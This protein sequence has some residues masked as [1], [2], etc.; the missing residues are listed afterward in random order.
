MALLE[1]VVKN[2][3]NSCSRN[4]ELIAINKRMSGGAE[5]TVQWEEHLLSMCESLGSIPEPQK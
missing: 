1:E 2:T 4:K 3:N 5:G